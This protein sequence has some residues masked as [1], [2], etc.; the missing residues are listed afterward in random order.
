MSKI[1]LTSV[2]ETKEKMDREKIKKILIQFIK[3]QTA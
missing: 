2:Y 3:R 1:T